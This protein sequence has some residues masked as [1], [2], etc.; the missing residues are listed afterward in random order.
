MDSASGVVNIYTAYMALNQIIAG[1]S[2][3][4]MSFP[5]DSGNIANI[6]WISFLIFSFS[7][8]KFSFAYLTGLGME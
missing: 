3:L 4:T 1:I 5:M 2:P 6:K 8:I 7:R